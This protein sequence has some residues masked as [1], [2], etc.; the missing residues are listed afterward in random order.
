MRA[1]SSRDCARAFNRQ[2]QRVTRRSPF[3]MT[4]FQ[5]VPSHSG[6]TSAAT[7]VDECMGLYGLCYLRTELRKGKAVPCCVQPVELHASLWT[8]VEIFSRAA[9]NVSAGRSLALP[10]RR[11]HSTNASLSALLLSSPAGGTRMYYCVFV[12]SKSSPLCPKYRAR[13]RFRGDHEP[14]R[15][16][17]H[18]PCGSAE[19]FTVDKRKTRGKITPIQDSASASVLHLPQN[20]LGQTGI[21]PRREDE[22]S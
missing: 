3:W 21:L 1:P 15:A 6:Q 9:G 16:R 20:S 17:M 13:R 10:V 7:F 8:R 22:Q 11:R 4:P 5:P 12:E 2:S 18:E 14:S 19:L